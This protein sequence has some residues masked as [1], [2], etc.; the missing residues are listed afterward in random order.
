MSKKI[1]GELNEHT[2]HLA[3]KNYI[4]PDVSHQ[5]KEIMG[6]VC[7]IVNENG[8]TEIETRSFSNLSKKIDRLLGVASV[9]VVFP[10]GHKIWLKWIDS[11]TGEI[12]QRKPSTKKGK[13]S[14]VIPELY[15]I[16]KSLS[17][18][19]L[20]LKLVFIEEE[21]FKRRTGKRRGVRTERVPI[22]IHSETTIRPSQGIR[23][24][25]IAIPEEEFTSKEF[26]KANKLRDRAA[27]YGLQ[28]LIMTGEI[29]KTGQRG[30]AFIYRLKAPSS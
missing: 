4:D 21:H 22:S 6:S 17:N 9:T 3:L 2:L 30:K 19:S 26:A 15:K 11:E 12:S 1:I 7:D 14:D 23:Q 16:R 5:E 8:I 28:L 18:P 29:E 24:L 25:F 20:T 27:W 13:A 10:I